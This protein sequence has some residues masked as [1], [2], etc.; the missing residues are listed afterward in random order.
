MSC[1]APR[2]ARIL[3][4]RASQALMTHDVPET[5]LDLVLAATF[6]G[7]VDHDLVTGRS[8]YS[9]RWRLMLGFEA[10]HEHELSSGFWKELTHRDDLAEV[11]LLW[12]DHVRNAWPFQ[13]TWRMK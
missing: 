4:E 10:G 13:H 11:E 6:E 1:S 5:L 8:H 2:G 7:L 9:H 12:S 3:V